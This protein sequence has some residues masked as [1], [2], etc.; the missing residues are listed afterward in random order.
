[1]K[2]KQVKQVAALLLSFLM[3]FVCTTTPSA[4]AADSAVP[5]SSLAPG[6]T[7]NFVG[8]AWIVLD[9]TAATC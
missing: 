3:V 8:C 9:P 6:D 7:V 2:N 1:M 5:L 4:A